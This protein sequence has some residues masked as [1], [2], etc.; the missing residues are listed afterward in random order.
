MRIG[1]VWLFTRRTNSPDRPY[2]NASP[3]K[4]ARDFDLV[5]SEIQRFAGRAYRQ[6]GVIHWGTVKPEAYKTLYDRNVRVLSGY[7][8]N[9][10]TIAGRFASNCPTPHVHTCPLMTAGWTMIAD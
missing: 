3:D 5:A 9:R 8:V 6:P 10:A 2:E 7:F 4:L 1:S